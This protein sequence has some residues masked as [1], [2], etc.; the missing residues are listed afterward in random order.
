MTYLIARAVGSAPSL[1]PV[2]F[3][4]IFDGATTLAITAVLTLATAT[5]VMFFANA[6]RGY[7]APIGVAILR[8]IFTQLV[9]WAGWGEYFLWSVPAL[10]SGIVKNQPVI[11]C[12][13][14]SILV[15][16]TVLAGLASPFLWWEFAD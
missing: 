6:G 3:Q 12:A 10:Y 16:L 2:P 11:F 8:L 1:P 7:L 4:V 14:S 13:A 15:G 9:T 5:P